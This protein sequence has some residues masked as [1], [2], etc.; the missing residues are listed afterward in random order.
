MR[1]DERVTLH[2]RA[3]TNVEFETR[4][5]WCDIQ[6]E[7]TA[8]FSTGG[9]ISRADAYR[10]TMRYHS[11]PSDMRHLLYNVT[12]RATLGDFTLAKCTVRDRGELL[13][14]SIVEGDERRRELSIT[15]TSRQ[16]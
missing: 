8:S 2:W 1:Y 14:T 4:E 11:M 7:G 10:L 16:P 12:Q 15:C 9:G 3:S 6:D 5:V 13:I